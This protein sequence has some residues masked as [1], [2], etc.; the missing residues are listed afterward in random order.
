MPVLRWKLKSMQEYDFECTFSDANLE[1]QLPEIV[2]AY[3]NLF[4]HNEQLIL[5][6]REYISNISALKEKITE[7]NEIQ[8]KLIDKFKEQ[9][10]GLKN[11]INKLKTLHS[12]ELKVKEEEL[13][14]K[15]EQKK[16]S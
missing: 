3:H 11:E 13:E 9:L 10:N 8:Q 6:E 15:L 1:K 4:M 16:K 2:G 7:E 5:K 12:L 14:E